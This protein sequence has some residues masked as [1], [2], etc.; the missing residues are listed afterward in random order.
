[1]D[2]EL[3]LDLSKQLAHQ[4]EAS[5]RT[6]RVEKVIQELTKPLYVWRMARAKV[7][8]V[9]RLGRGAQTTYY[10]AVKEIDDILKKAYGSGD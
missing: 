2:N 6:A 7:F 3:T 1:M 5:E 8:R 9:G 10:R 4:R